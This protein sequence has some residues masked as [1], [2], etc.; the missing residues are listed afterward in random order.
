MAD[1]E[2]PAELR[3]ASLDGVPWGLVAGDEVG[4]WRKG[5]CCP[6]TRE[7]GR[8]KELPG[9]LLQGGWDAMVVRDGSW[10]WGTGGR[11]VGLVTVGFSRLGSGAVRMAQVALRQSLRAVAR[12]WKDATGASRSAWPVSRR[13]VVR[14]E[15]LITAHISRE[16]YVVAPRAEWGG[17]PVH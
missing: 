17:K 3:V 14:T 16:R 10:S 9:R 12:A 4:G 15:L 8:E 1:G 2:P 13:T 7:E 5:V 6:G 11:E